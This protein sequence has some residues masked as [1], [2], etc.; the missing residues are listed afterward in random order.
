MTAVMQLDIESGK[1]VVAVSGGVDSVALLDMLAHM[2]RLELVVAHYE[3]GIRQSSDNDRKFVEALSARYGLPFEYEHGN[4]GSEASEALARERRYNFLER[5]RAKHQAKAVI[6]AHHQDDVLETA[7]INILRG[8]G[9]RG[10]SA[11]G[12]REGILRPLTKFSKKD[13]QS[14]ATAHNLRWREDETNADTRYL[15]NYVRH[16]IIPML[17]SEGRAGLLASVRRAGEQNQAINQLLKGVLAD[18]V[19]DTGGLRRYQFVMLP[20]ALATEVV[21]AWLRSNGIREVD[22]LLIDR[23]TIA[24]KNLPAGKQVDV[25]A[26]YVLESRKRSVRLTRRAENTTESV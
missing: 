7:V 4:L 14:Y 1:Y 12:S 8:T 20:H 9:R 2:P 6:T 18:V 19:D 15:R 21:L 16:N 5:V 22:R 3:H 26:E 25:S 24:A 17:G 11:L 10:L 13:L 23:L